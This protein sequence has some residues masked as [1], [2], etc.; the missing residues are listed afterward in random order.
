M[1]KAAVFFRVGETFLQAKRSNNQKEENQH[2]PEGRPGRIL[3][4]EVRTDAELKL[5]KEVRS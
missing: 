5:R 1:E 4:N 2:L 3:R